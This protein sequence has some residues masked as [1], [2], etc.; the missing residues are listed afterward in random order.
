LLE[1]LHPLAFKVRVESSVTCNIQ[2]Y[3]AKDKQK[4][5]RNESSRRLG[6]AEGTSQ[7]LAKDIL[8]YVVGDSKAGRNANNV[9]CAS[10]P[11]LTIDFAAE[12]LIKVSIV[13]LLQRRKTNGQDL[14][15]ISVEE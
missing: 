10:T 6:K 11:E 3:T 9:L 5:V 4:R 12:E 1:R 2:G 13:H 8:G 15:E 14:I 7:V